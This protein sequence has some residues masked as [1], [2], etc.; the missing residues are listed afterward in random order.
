MNDLFA[1]IEE[2]KD[3]RISIQMADGIETTA[4]ELRRCEVQ[5]VIRRYFPYGDPKP[6]FAEVEKKRGKDAADC[7]RNDVRAAWKK[8]RIEETGQA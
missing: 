8:R 7:L 2:A 5:S 3:E 4:E 6:L 1:S